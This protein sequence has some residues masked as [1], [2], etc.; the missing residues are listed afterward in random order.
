MAGILNGNRAEPRL[1]YLETSTN[2]AL[3]T[4]DLAW[5]LGWVTLDKSPT[6][7]RP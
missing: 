5:E 1:L 4:E 3:G 6:S 7:L 2:T